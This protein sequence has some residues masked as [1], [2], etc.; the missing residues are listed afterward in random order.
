MAFAPVDSQSQSNGCDISDAMPGEILR[1]QRA[2]LVAL[3]DI[4]TAR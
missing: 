2:L 1:P 3:G 4:K